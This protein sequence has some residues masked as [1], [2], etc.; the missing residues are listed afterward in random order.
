MKRTALLLALALLFTGTAVARD[1]PA[2]EVEVL[3]HAART[4]AG[5]LLPAYPEGQPEVRI[6][7][8]RIPAGTR[9]PMHR[10]PVIN[11]GVLL[12][13]ELT[14]VTEDGARLRLQAGDAL[15]EVVD[16]PHYGVNEGDAT[17]EIIVFYAGV[18]G[19]PITVYDPDSSR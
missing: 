9:L 6:L 11:A 15:V 14:F 10:H 16:R 13:G 12:A 17:A 8:I 4:W 1:V 2:V 5:E 18:E 7:R 3:A 19:A